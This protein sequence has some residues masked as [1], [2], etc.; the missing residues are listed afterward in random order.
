MLRHN[1]SAFATN[2]QDWR[3]CSLSKELTKTGSTT[4]C[5]GITVLIYWEKLKR[6]ILKIQI[7]PKLMVK[8][9]GRLLNRTLMRKVPVLV[10]LY[11][12]KKVYFEQQKNL[13]ERLLYK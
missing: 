6:T 5:N 7:R 11:F 13:N 10:K 2:D 1:S 8:H 4:R 9:S 12:Q 3:I